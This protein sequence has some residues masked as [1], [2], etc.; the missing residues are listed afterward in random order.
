MLVSAAVAPVV[1]Q[2]CKQSLL[3]FVERR[4]QT[5]DANTNK[6][7]TNDND[8]KNSI[9]VSSA[10]EHAKVL[11]VLEQLQVLNMHPDA[12]VNGGSGSKA[13]LIELFPVLCGCIGTLGSTKEERAVSKA[14]ANL[15]QMVGEE[16]FR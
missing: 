4:K 8:D 5:E 9:S 11:Q 3:E 12:K 7:N 15:F 1:L 10:S 13:H 16:S 2:R 14:L 6:N